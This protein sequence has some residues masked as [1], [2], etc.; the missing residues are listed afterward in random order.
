MKNKQDHL[1]ELITTLG[2]K[3]QFNGALLV[4]DQGEIIYKEVYGFAEIETNRSLTVKSVF[5][6]A[7]VSKAFTAAGI[8]TLY[9]HGKLS[10]DDLVERWIPDFPYQGITIRNLLH[11]T[12]G[13]PDYMSLFIEKWDRSKIAV[14]QDVLDM[15]KLHQPPVLFQPNDKWEYSNTGYVVL[16]IIIEKVSGVCFAD[17]MKTHV[18]Q[19]LGMNDTRVFNRRYSNDRILDYAFGYTYSY[20]THR[21][22]LPDHQATT[23]YVIYL[24]GIQGDGVVNS[25]LDDLYQWDQSLY[26]EKLFKNETLEEAFSPARLNTN[27]TFD[28]G[29]GWILANNETTG[30]VVTHSGGWPGYSTS[31][32]R[33]IDHNK[34]IIYLSNTDKQLELQQKTIE[35]VEKIL[36]DQPYSIPEPPEE[37]QPVEIDKTLYNRY[38]GTYQFETEGLISVTKEDDRLFAQIIGQPA[39]EIL[40]LSETRFF[41]RELQIQL[42][43]FTDQDGQAKELVIYQYGEHKAVCILNE[44]I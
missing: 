32:I 26:T 31:L 17:Y 35:A 27:D 5:E 24:D 22:C 3:G 11:H 7:S 4:A 39:Y 36:F 2:E 8:M 12:S 44:Q 16:A 19:P 9:E 34:T 40:P 20:E 1:H 42:E 41:V 14:N 29:F 38:V 43:F 28:Y 6:L 10:Y 33:Y 13:L 23:D 15:L 18:F 21:Y 30:R 25:N 37:L